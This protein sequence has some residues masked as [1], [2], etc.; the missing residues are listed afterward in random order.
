VGAGCVG[1][2]GV[3]VVLATKEIARRVGNE[4]MVVVLATKEIAHRA[5]DKLVLI[6]L[7]R[8]GA[9]ACDDGQHGE[10][11]GP[12]CWQRGHCV[13]WGGRPGQVADPLSH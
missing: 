8:M 11:S 3:I 4:E 5:G 1:D 7:A 12:L 9:H 2:E 6:V 10:D 13:C